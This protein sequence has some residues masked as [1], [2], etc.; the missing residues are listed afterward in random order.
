MSDIF[1]TGSFYCQRCGKQTSILID[2]M[3]QPCALPQ[4]TLELPQVHVSVMSEP[5][6]QLELWNRLEALERRV[7]ELEKR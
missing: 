5:V 2:S 4:P 3:C 7:A 6:P 1:N